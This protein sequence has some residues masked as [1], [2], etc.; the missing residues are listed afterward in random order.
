VAQWMNLIDLTYKNKPQQS[1]TH[2]VQIKRIQNKNPA[3][4]DLA[5]LTLVWSCGF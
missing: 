4:V 2:I 1:N 3:D 5:K